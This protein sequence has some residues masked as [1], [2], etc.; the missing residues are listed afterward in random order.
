MMLDIYNIGGREEMLLNAL[1]PITAF[2]NFSFHYND[3]IDSSNFGLGNV[4]EANLVKVRDT[5]PTAR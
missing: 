2:W 4:L 3:G 1:K 5:K